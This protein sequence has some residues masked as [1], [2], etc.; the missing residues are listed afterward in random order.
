MSKLLQVLTICG[1]CLLVNCKRDISLEPIVLPINTDTIKPK[2]RFEF[3]NRA[4]YKQDSTALMW[5]SAVDLYSK[6]YNPQSN[7][8]T[9]DHTIYNRNNLEPRLNDSLPFTKFN[10][11]IGAQ[12]AY[13][14]RIFWSSS[15]GTQ[16]AREIIFATKNWPNA[17]D[18]FKV[19]KDTLIKF[20][21]PDDTLPNNKFIRIQ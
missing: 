2:I 17:C 18:T 19:A 12:Y 6:F 7:I 16:H 13:Q 10:N 11:M 20:I 1:L 8:S 4:G 3:V 14:V 9:L 21:Y 5:F 15:L